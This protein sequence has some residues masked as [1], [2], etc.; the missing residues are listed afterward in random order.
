MINSIECFFKS[1]KTTKLNNFL[2]KFMYHSLVQSSNA[3]AVEWDF[4]KP[5]WELLSNPNLVK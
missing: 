4:L 5:N 1:I 3:V 2:S